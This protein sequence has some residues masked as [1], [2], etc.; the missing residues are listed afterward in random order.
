MYSFSIRL[1]SKDLANSYAKALT[2]ADLSKAIQKVYAAVQ[3]GEADGAVADYV[4][5]TMK[6]INAPSNTH[7]TLRAIGTH[8]FLGFNVSSGLYSYYKDHRH[9]CRCCQPCLVLP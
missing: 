3:S 1:L 9:Q 5:N 2:Q 4:D 8:Y 7:E 6:E